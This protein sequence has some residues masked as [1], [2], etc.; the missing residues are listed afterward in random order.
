MLNRFFVEPMVKAQQVAL[1][2]AEDEA[3]DEA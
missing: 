1:E 2:Q 3:S